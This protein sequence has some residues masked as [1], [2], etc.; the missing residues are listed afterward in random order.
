MTL[1]S[2]PAPPPPTATVTFD[3]LLEKVR[4]FANTASPVAGAPAP[5]PAVVPASAAKK[6]H[7]SAGLTK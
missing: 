6:K 5:A 7:K 1:I 4:S 3:Q 2:P